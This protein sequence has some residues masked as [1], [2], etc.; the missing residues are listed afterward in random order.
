MEPA[1]RSVANLYLRALS[2]QEPGQPK[3][4]AIVLAGTCSSFDCSI[5][6]RG[7]SQAGTTPGA[8]QLAESGLGGLITTRL[9]L[10]PR[11][12]FF[13]QLLHS[14]CSFYFSLWMILPLHTPLLHQTKGTNEGKINT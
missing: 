9:Y 8:K 1:G 6:F 3:P 13:P 4:V 10:K 14:I 5:R 7:V 11:F 2:S 12:F